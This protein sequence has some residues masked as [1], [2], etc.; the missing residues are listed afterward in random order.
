[1]SQR[2]RER[3]VA[4]DIR[5]A[6]P[7]LAA[8]MRATVLLAEMGEAKKKAADFVISASLASTDS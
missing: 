4:G 8:L 3:A 2:S 5:G 1:M 6:V 7:H